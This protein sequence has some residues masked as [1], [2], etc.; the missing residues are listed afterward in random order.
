MKIN[1]GG[2]IR[3]YNPSVTSAPDLH[4]DLD[5]LIPVFRFRGTLGSGRFPSFSREYDLA[6]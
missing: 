4:Q 6:V 3:T 2:R 5:Y 1:S